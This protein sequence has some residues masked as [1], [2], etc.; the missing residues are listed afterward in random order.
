MGSQQR[1]TDPWPQFK[2]VCEL[3]K[4]IGTLKAVEVGLPGD[5]GG[6]N[7]IQMPLPANLDYDAWLGA[8]P[9]VYYTGTESRRK[10]QA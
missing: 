9:E 3:V 5:P 8:T 7:K 4:Q 10:M 1:S 2:R 6:G